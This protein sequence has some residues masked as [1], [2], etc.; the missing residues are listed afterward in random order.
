MLSKKMEEAL[1]AQIN[2]EIFSTYLYLAMAAWFHSRKLEGFARWMEMQAREEWEHSMKFFHYVDERGGRV[3][4][5]AIEAPPSE[6]ESPLEAFKAAYEHEKY[7]TG[8]IHDLVAL[9]REEKD[10]AT[11]NFLQWFVTEQVEEESS[12]NAIV[13][14]MK[15]VQGSKNGLYMIDRELGKRTLASATAEE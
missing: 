2:A 7:I 6:W 15:L 1:N 13:Q 11:E 4:L 10:Y 3:I 12:V 9:A 5:S 8:R 14:Q